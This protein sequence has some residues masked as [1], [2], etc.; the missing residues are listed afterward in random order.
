MA[1]FINWTA[2]VLSVATM[3]YVFT[4]PPV[5]DWIIVFFLKGFLSL[6]CD[7][8]FVSK[9]WISYPDRF[10]PNVFQTTIVFAVLAY[11]MLCVLYNQTSY[12]SSLRGILT[13]AVLYSIPPTLFEWWASENTRLVAFN[14]WTWYYSFLFFLGTFLAVRGIIEL[15]RTYSNHKGSP[16]PA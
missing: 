4:K 14:G 13:Q 2:L 15:I 5:K 12:R 16:S 9:G 10:F 3:F 7:T 8:Y 6:L 1:G 11:P